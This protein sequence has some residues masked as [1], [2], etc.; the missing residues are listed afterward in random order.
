MQKLCN[1]IVKIILVK[2]KIFAKTVKD[3][4]PKND[5]NN[6]FI[7]IYKYLLLNY[8]YNYHNKT[9]MNTNKP[10]SNIF[11]KKILH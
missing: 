2:R 10:R 5:L 6:N 9:S 7:K 11:A 8:Y 1:F 3:I 4:K